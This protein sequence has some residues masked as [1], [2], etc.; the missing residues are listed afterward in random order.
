MT[1]RYFNWVLAIVLL[2]AAVVLVVTA[3]GLR[4]WQR[5]RMMYVAREIGLKAYE[6]CVWED[7]A[8]NLG[9]Y[10]S[11]DSADV[12]ILLKYA[13]SQLSIR[14]IKR[15][16][17]QQAIAAYRSIL[18]LDK[19]NSMAIEKL[20]G[21]Y[22]QMNI[23]AEAELVAERYLQ[24][25]KNPT[26]R[27]MLA[28]ALARQR[29]FKQ[30]ADQLQSII[31]EHPEQV[32]AYEILGQLAESNPADFPVSDEKWF[33]EAVERNPFSSQALIVRG[34]FYL[35][36]HENVKA[37]AD[38]EKAEQLDL[39]NSQ[40]RLRLAAEFVNAS[41]FDRARTHLAKV[42]A[43]DPGNMLLWEI[44]AVL[45]MKTMSKEEMLSVAKNGLRGLVSNPWDFMPV[46]AELFIRGGDVENA[47]SCLDK[48]KQ[49]DIAPATV[50]FLEGLLAEAEKRD[51]KAIIFWR[52]AK[53]LGDRS[54]KTQMSLAGA[55]SR[56]GD[57]QSAILELNDL[58]GQQPHLL[59]PHLELARLFSQT[60]S[61]SNAAE[62]ARLAM[63]IAPK[64]PESVLHYIRAQ[65][66]LIESNRAEGNTQIWQDLENCLVDLKNLTGDPFEVELLKF[67]LAMQR[68]RL[69]YA[70]QLLTD[71]KTGKEGRIEVATAEVELLK[72]QGRISEAI[73]KLYTL[74]EQ[75][76]QAVLPVEYLANLLAVHR[77]RGDCE[78][79]LRDVLQRIEDPGARRELSLLLADF[80]DQWQESDKSYQL[81]AA[82]SIELLYDIPVKRR[83][84]THKQVI[85][86]NS[87]AGQLV[88][89]IKAVEG[90]NGWQW[91]YEQAKI[92]LRGVDFKERYPQI[93]VLLKENTVVNS[94]DQ[95]SRMLLAA[96]YERG[97][98]LQLAIATYREALNR[99]TEDVGIIVAAVAAMYK[100]GE[101]EQADE[102]LN[103]AERQGLTHPE[104][105]KLRLQSYLRRGKLNLAE[106]ILEDLMNKDPNNESIQLPLALVQMQQNKYDR[107]YEL[108][109]KLK[110]KQPGSLS[111][112][113]ALV[114][115]NVRQKKN[116]EALALCDEVVN[117]CGDASAYILRGRT[118]V[119]L[120]QNE[121][122]KQDFD[123]AVHIEPNNVQA[124]V[125]K[126][127]F[128]RSMGQSEE[129][130]ADMQKALELEP[131]NVGIRKRVIGFLLSCDEPSKKRKG[132][133]LLDE[134]LSAN[135]QDTEL[136]LCQVRLLLDDGNTPAVEQAQRIL[137]KITDEEPKV[138]DAWVL[139]AQIYLRKA[140]FDKVADTVLRGLGYLPEN[141][142]LLLMKAQAEAW[143]SP[144]LAIP[145]LKSL[146]ELDPNNADV[147]VN[148][149]K[150]YIAA[151]QYEKGIKLLKNHVPRSMIDDCRKI[152]I[153]LASALY[154]SGD[155]TAAKQEFDLLYKSM[156]NDSNVFLAQIEMLKEDHDWDLLS[157]RV[158]EWFQSSPNDVTMFLAVASSLAKTNND[159]ARAI[160]ESLLRR[161]LG[162]HPNCLAAMTTL[163]VLLQNT[164]HTVES[165]EIYRR[166]LEIEPDNVVAINN[167]AWIM[168]EEQG[169]QQE[170]LGL[171]QR[172]LK[173]A[174][175]YTDLIDTCGV[176]HYRL[177]EYH[178]AVRDFDKCIELYPRDC[179]SLAGSYFHLARTLEALGQ[180]N[181]K[182]IDSLRK[183]LSLSSKIGGLSKVEMT[184]AT[185]LLKELTRDQNGVLVTNK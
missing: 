156:P 11:I 158:N 43:Q 53:Q 65:M 68:G 42:E 74:V 130:L 93:V 99:S 168:C 62:H 85:E 84:L 1:K 152:K 40:V 179:P 162:Q 96:A 111:V 30:A 55:L 113:S 95:T 131:G 41:M 13:E 165:G 37:L 140:Q 161:I 132:I 167:L 100:A 149:A 24:T 101:Y 150:T 69:D 134:T 135:L 5:K 12:Q 88:D 29:R 170:A 9:R 166:V 63:Q 143:R 108:L 115:L 97:G 35:R 79:V 25:N 54:E 139:L 127:D 27:R 90:E 92:W 112:M 47:R 44:W 164:G 176:I 118:Y 70:E 60:G 153:T 82:L 91:R 141:K 3:F 18:R 61:W 48:L 123:R 151:G 106:S 49:K 83:L 122:A 172:G 57:N 34:G 52:K 120:G 32:P 71:L 15:D 36:N 171:A 125:V 109:N 76:P 178:K 17:V 185:N 147:V 128:N 81:L 19:N 45:A 159:D 86:N 4:K 39:S 157:G 114:E 142:S 75:F 146:Y 26:V 72:A 23:A 7:A 2:I 182:A 50:A 22:L 163:A 124:W 78:K 133:E 144:I 121:L 8:K 33:N 10:L 103:R 20:V 98:E 104:L 116:Q 137:Q 73:S 66:G 16:N 94:D 160:A 38:L 136:R 177:G 102:I 6:N 173:S 117:R 107:A 138:A 77:G 56:A 51:Y 181:D 21:L 129:S 87:K 184:E 183:A 110:D 31:Q 89:E 119:M 46:A 126:S 80:Y 67:R 169:R 145:T 28:I 59:R 148:L 154:K 174:P 175:E 180:D 155:K 64:N 105:P 14:P 58:V